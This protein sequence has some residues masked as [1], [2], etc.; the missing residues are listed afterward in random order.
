MGSEE[1]KKEQEC[2]RHG[3]TPKGCFR[4]RNQHQRCE[5]CAFC[6][7]DLE[8][9]PQAF[10]CWWREPMGQRDHSVREDD[11]GGL[12]GDGSLMLVFA[13]WAFPKRA[14]APLPI[15][16]SDLLYKPPAP[17]SLQNAEEAQLLYGLQKAL[18]ALDQV[19]AQLPPQPGLPTL[20]D[21]SE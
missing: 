5:F 12:Q 21:H 11:S 15:P 19:P 1:L 14:G 9:H 8:W 20:T 13:L 18:R 6:W 7:K 17:R 10:S 3:G 2:V 4:Q 16:P